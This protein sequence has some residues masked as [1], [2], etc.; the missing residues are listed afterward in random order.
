MAVIYLRNPEGG[1]KVACSEMEAQYDE[2]N[3]WRRFDPDNPDA[4][5]PEPVPLPPEPE[6]QWPVRALALNKDGSE[7]KKPGPKPAAKRAPRA[8]AKR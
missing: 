1:A 3:G 8:A 6:P 5:F 4:V 2:A 7:R